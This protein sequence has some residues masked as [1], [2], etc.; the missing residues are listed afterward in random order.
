MLTMCVAGA[1]LAQPCKGR[2]YN[3]CMSSCFYYIGDVIYKTCSIPPLV[4]LM[5]EAV[6]DFIKLAQQTDCNIVQI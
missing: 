5:L 4:S 6:C 1:L 3:V 2:L